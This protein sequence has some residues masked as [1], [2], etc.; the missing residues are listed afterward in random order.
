[1]LGAYKTHRERIIEQRELAQLPATQDRVPAFREYMALGS[2]IVAMDAEARRVRADMSR[3]TTEFARLK[4]RKWELQRHGGNKAVRDEVVRE[5]A[6]VRDW[7]ARARTTVNDAFLTRVDVHRRRGALE[8]SGFTPEALAATRAGLGAAPEPQ[9]VERRFV[10]ACPVDGCRGF[11]SERWKCGTCEAAVCAKCHEPKAEG[12][13]CDP[14][15]AASAAL[16]ASD[17]K[18]CPGC[19]SLIFK[20]S[21][22]QQVESRARVCGARGRARCVRAMLVSQTCASILADVLHVVQHGVRLEVRTDGGRPRPHPQPSLLRV[23]VQDAWRP[24][25]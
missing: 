3:A 21:G 14:D 4:L 17:S 8:T 11:L 1:M 16:I 13:V 23:V 9:P 22:C 12:H 15:V 6:A 25:P 2:V 19:A 18:P 7:I 5:M 10:R 24:R 20:I